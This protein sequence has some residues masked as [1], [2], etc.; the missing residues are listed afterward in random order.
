MHSEDKMIFHT[1]SSLQLQLLASVLHNWTKR[2][3]D[4]SSFDKN[5]GIKKRE[6][7]RIADSR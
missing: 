2:T 6:L 5:L 1:I 4:Q 3:V 7:G